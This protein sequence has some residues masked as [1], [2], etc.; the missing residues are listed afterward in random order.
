MDG[1]SDHY[2]PEL[3]E[4][5]LR[6]CQLVAL[7]LGYLMDDLVVVGGLVPTLLTLGGAIQM[8][9]ES[10]SHVGTT[11]LDIGLALAVLD[12]DRYTEISRALEDAGFA[13]DTSAQGNPTPQRWRGPLGVTID[14]LMEPTPGDEPGGIKRLEGNRFSAFATPGIALAFRDRVA[15][16]IRGPGPDGAVSAR[17]IGVCGPGAFVVLKAL[18]FGSRTTD[19]DAYDLHYVLAHFGDGM[20]DV[21]ERMRP[22]LDS[23]AAQSAIE[24]L[25]HDFADLDHVGPVAV[26][27][28]LNR[29]DDDDLKRDVAGAVHALLRALPPG[30]AAT[31]H[32]PTRHVGRP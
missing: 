8:D 19:K 12:G 7:R 10:E 16:E 11:D 24:I 20:A 31:S 9:D 6:V 32:G 28:F 22:L 18:A 30:D 1:E 5:V 26:A 13:P 21:A 25:R 27:R 2:T 23:P 3:T 17:M 4:K 14:F 15:V 29:A